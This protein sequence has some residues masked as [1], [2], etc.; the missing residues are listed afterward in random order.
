MRVHALQFEVYR[1]ILRNDGGNQFKMPHSGIRTRQ[2]NGE[3]ICDLSVPIDAYNR[4][5]ELVNI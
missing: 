1:E 5:L 2:K 3:E 4:A